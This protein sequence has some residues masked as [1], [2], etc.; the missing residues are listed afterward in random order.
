MR[1]VLSGQILRSRLPGVPA[2]LQYDDP[3]VTKVKLQNSYVVVTS[4]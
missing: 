3:A 2:E 4:G 1:I